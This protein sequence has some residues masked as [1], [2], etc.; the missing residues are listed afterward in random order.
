[1][2][3][4]FYGFEKMVSF[5]AG[6]RA[7]SW[8]VVSCVGA[9]IMTVCVHELAS[10]MDS[11]MIVFWR[12]L[13][14]VLLLTPVMLVRGKELRVVHL[15]LHIYRGLLMTAALHLGFYALAHLPIAK[16]TVLFFL[17]PAFT[18][19]MA[20][21]LLGEKIRLPRIIAVIVGFAGALIILRPEQMQEVEVAM[22][23]A[24]ACA[25]CFSLSLLI[26][27]QMVKTESTASIFISGPVIAGI[28]TFPLAVPVWHDPTG[29]EWVWLLLLV[30]GASLRMF[31]DI[32]AYRDGDAGFIA[33]FF[34]LRLVFVGI[35]GYFIFAEVPD[36]S[37][38]LGSA[39]I[40]GAM[41]FIAYREAVLR[42]RISSDSP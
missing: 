33:P 40:I 2:Q 10:S 24:I 21:P 11:R 16:A 14:I 38:L 7:A 23:A 8:A 27:K 6:A 32:R 12:C 20:W 37:T 39:V 42:K 22:F 9:T 17:A 29:V 31:A 5:S 25:F 3:R 35:A 36:S 18:T 30:A 13:L 26:V 15:R 1:M 34:Y 19:V 28:C 4:K 41:L